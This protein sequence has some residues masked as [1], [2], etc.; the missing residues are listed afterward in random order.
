MTEYP[1]LTAE[2]C[3]KS[4]LMNSQFTIDVLKS[5][6]FNIYRGEVLGIV[7]ESGCGKST[8]A[9]TIM[10]IYKLSSGAIYFNGNLISTSKGYARNKNEIQKKIQIIFQDSTSSLN[11]NMTVS[12]LI[13]EPFVIHKIYQNKHEQESKVDELLLSVGLGMQY[14]SLYPSEISCGQCQRVNIARSIALEPEL[15]IADE[16]VASLDVSI[17]AQ[18]ITLFQNLQS[19]KKFSF[20]FISHD[21]SIVRIISD[22]V[23]VMYRGRIVEMTSTEKLFTSPRHPYTQSLLSAIPVPDPLYER[24]K[25]KFTIDTSTINESGKFKEVEKGHWVYC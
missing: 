4:F 1:L 17:Q 13:A 19:K 25:S 23:A 5:V 8:L 15:I 10:G 16:P 20:I 14:K 21:L 22:R 9:R 7:G 3:N 24:Q 12:E 11:P 6:S 18:I 2:K